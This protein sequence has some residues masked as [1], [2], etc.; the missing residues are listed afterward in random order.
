MDFVHREVEPQASERTSFGGQHFLGN[1]EYWS[2]SAGARAQDSGTVESGFRHDGGCIL[3]H[4]HATAPVRNRWRIPELFLAKD[5]KEVV[6]G[7]AVHR[8]KT[9]RKVTGTVEDLLP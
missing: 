2:P 6:D 3:Q 8:P 1:P 5:L 7:G 9:F 4:P